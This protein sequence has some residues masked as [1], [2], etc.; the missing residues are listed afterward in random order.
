MAL[1][2][3]TICWSAFNQHSNEETQSNH[4]EFDCVLCFESFPANSTV[5]V[6]S[7]T[8]G[9]TNRVHALCLNTWINSSSNPQARCPLCR[10]QIA[11]PLVT[12]L[13]RNERTRYFQQALNRLFAEHPGVFRPI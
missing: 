8:N 10:A 4:S 1:N 6:H 12:N 5:L 7:G 3:N 2:T 13:V 11:P 9:T